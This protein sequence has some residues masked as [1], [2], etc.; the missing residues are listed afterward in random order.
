LIGFL[1]GS[2]PF[3]LF[4][5]RYGPGAALL[6]LGGNAIAG[7]DGL[8]F[9]E[10]VFQ[11][12]ANFS[13]FGLTAALGIRP[14]WEVRWL[15][16]PLVPLAIAFWVG[17]VLYLVRYYRLNKEIRPEILL[18][19][20]PVFCLILGFIATPFGADPSGRYF[21]PLMVLLSIFAGGLVLYL[22]NRFG[23]P[24]WGLVGLILVFHLWGTLDSISRNPPGITTQF[25][26]TTQVDHSFDGELIRFLGSA[27]T[28]KGYS[29]YWVT[30]PLAFLSGESLI[31]APRLPYHQDFR[32][33]E[34]DDRYPPYLETVETSDEIAY[35]TTRHPELDDRLRAGFSERGITWL[36]ERIGDYLVFYHLSEPVRPADLGLGVTTP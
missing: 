14:P 1:I 5:T 33:T 22:T 3:W 20:G 6:E 11:R 27:G 29:N 7:I 25:D 28:T 4:V 19:A 23:W 35:I 13:I 9:L 10:S 8:P 16:A 24:A 12:L 2:S 36:E 30:Y 26:S 34:R 15:G 18:M 31:F 32:Y 17:V 21:L